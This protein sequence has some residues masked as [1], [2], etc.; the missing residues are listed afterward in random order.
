M[1]GSNQKIQKIESSEIVVNGTL[2][3]YKSVCLKTLDDINKRK[4]ELNAQDQNLLDIINDQLN[5]TDLST[6]QRIKLIDQLNSV[7]DRINDGIK[8]SGSI[9]KTVII[10]ATTLAGIFGFA[11]MIRNND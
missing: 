5:S 1:F 6:D 7:A 2:D 9:F 10:C 3:F 11:K 8:D 4:S